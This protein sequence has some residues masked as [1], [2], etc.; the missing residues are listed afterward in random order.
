MTLSS[1]KWPCV[2][3]RNLCSQIQYGFTA[4]A[5]SEPTG[6]KFL[7][8]TDIAPENI[9]WNTVPY[10][11]IKLN[12]QGK[13]LLHE[14]DIVIARTGATTGYAKYIESNPPC[15]F[16]S[17]LVRIR[18]NDNVC[19]RYA[20]FVIESEFYKRYIKTQLGGTAQPN[21]NAQILTSFPLPLP[22]LPIQRKIAAILSAYDDLIENNLRRIK[23]L[24]EMAQN[25]Y[26]EWFVKF[27]FPGHEKVKI[28]DSPLGRI[29]EGWVITNVRELIDE[30]NKRNKENRNLPVLSVTHNRSFI[31][32][33]E[34][35]SKRVY[36]KSVEK[37]KVLQKSDFAFNPSR[38]NIGSIAILNE[39]DEAIVSPMYIVFRVKPNRITPFFLWQVLNQGEVFKQIRQLCFG[40]VRQTF[41]LQDFGLVKFVLSPID[42]RSEYE[43]IVKPVFAEIDCLFLQVSNLRQTR[44]LLLPKLISGELDVSDLGIKTGDIE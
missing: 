41:K 5:R 6:V 42:L 35:F 19:S 14:G 8:I 13:Y 16:A 31:V 34:Y 23:I 2:T 12:E 44:D 38:L 15:V 33:E 27:C 17:Y 37:Y 18:L 40:T 25:L 10:C 9:N 11:D 20:G 32:S 4:S 30:Q 29:P 39:Y 26:K 21:A 43:N 22:P 24:E 3:V 36:S 28:V 7:R 1:T